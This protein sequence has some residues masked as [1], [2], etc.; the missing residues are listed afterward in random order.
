LGGIFA[1]KGCDF[2]KI[3]G[4]PSLWGWGYEDTVIYNRALEHGIK[5]N[6]DNFYKIGDHN[7]LH[8]LDEF[9]KNISVKSKEDYHNNVIVDG[10]NTLHNVQ[11]VFNYDTNMLDIDYF[12]CL[13][14]SN[15]IFK[16][17][18][19]FAVQKNKLGSFD[20]YRK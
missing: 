10:L 1:I 18:S 7:I 14:P 3:N 2:E 20:F 4:F 15:Q 17:T 16:N 12:N 13:Y 8:L 9:S 5:I 6:R 19:L 11:F